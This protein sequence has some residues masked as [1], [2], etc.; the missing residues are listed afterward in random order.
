MA[1][2]NVGNSSSMPDRPTSPGCRTARSTPD[3]ISGPAL[4]P[5]TQE[6]RL[7][8]PAGSATSRLLAGVY[9]S[10][11]MGKQGQFQHMRQ[12]TPTPYWFFNAPVSILVFYWEIIETQ[13]TFMKDGRFEE[14][15]SSWKE[16]PAPNGGFDAPLLR[17]QPELR[18][19]QSGTHEIKTP[20]GLLSYSSDTVRFRFSDTRNDFWPPETLT[21]KE[22]QYTLVQ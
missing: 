19:R 13:L 8:V 1:E 22:H 15:M 20:T 11:R 18:S 12:P 4:G 17:T 3:P 9:R 14:V 5:R 6:A 10:Q 2:P 16:Y 7:P 21:V